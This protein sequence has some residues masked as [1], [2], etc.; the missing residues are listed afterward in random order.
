MH[1][2]TKKFLE[3]A[4]AGES[5]AHMRYTIFAE[6]A[7][8]KGLKKLAN[9]W[10]AIAYAEFVHAKNHFKALGRLG[11]VPANL[12]MSIDGETFEVNEM[13]PVYN[14]AAQFQ[15]ENDAVRSTHFA[16]EAEKIHAGMYTKALDLSKQGKDF[17]ADKI[18]ICPVCGY[19]VEG[20]PPE[21]CPVCGA[22][23]DKFREFN[24][25]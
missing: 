21:K 23:R 8:Q 18:F 1:D 20:E 16:L 3:D 12:Q 6:D 5:Q 25:D 13:Y 9:L 11:D 22:P 2:M 14:N 4:F 24:A 19:T 15:G 7:E 17:E 10:R